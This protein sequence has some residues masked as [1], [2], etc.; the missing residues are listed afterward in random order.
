MALLLKNYEGTEHEREKVARLIFDSD[1]VFNSLVYG[2]NA[3]H[4]IEA[5]LDLG[6]NYFSPQFTRCV[7]N[8]NQIVGIA[9]AFPVSQKTEIDQKSGKDFAKAMGIFRFLSLMPLFIRMEKMMPAVTGTT[10]GYLHTLC[11]D[12]EQRGKGLGGQTIQ[13]IAEELGPLHLHVNGD[14]AKAIA[15]YEKNGFKKAARGQM[16][17]KGRPLSQILMSK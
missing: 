7:M 11:I 1:L 16:I 3:L 15:F 4:V 12:S 8:E 10:G 14:N 17:H 6:D 5:L 13:Q 2:K 9:V